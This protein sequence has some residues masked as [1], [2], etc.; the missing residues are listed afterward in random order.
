MMYAIKTITQ[1]MAPIV[2]FMTEHVWQE[3]VLRYST[4]TAES[5]HLTDWPTVMEGVEKY[6]SVIDSVDEVR[7]IISLVLK[8]RNEKQVRIRQ[9]LSKLY[10]CRED[11]KVEIDETLVS[12]MLGEVNV[13]ELVVLD[14]PDA[15][16]IK[17]AGLDFRKAGAFLK[18]DVNKVKGMLLELSDEDMASVVASIEAGATVTVPGYGKEMPAELFTLTAVSKPNISIVK[19]GG[20]IVSLDMNITDE[21][22]AEGYLRDILRQCQVC[23]KEADFNVSDSI[24]VYFEAENEAAKVIA[25]NKEYIEAELLAAISETPLDNADYTGVIELDIGNVKVQMSKA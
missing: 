21:L 17:L 5:V 15:L 13:K 24:N 6:A 9:P 12:I 23:R 2:P 22:L 7:N 16:E 3:V 10:L 14:T 1:V 8:L 25:D 4:E 19:D 20:Y 18:G 11:G